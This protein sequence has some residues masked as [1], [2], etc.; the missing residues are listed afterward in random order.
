MMGRREYFN[1]HQRILRTKSCSERCSSLLFLFPW[2]LEQR[3][4]L[5][6]FITSRIFKGREP[7]VSLAFSFQGSH[8]GMS[9]TCLS[10][11][12][13]R[14]CTEKGGICQELSIMQKKILLVLKSDVS[15]FIPQM[16]LRILGWA[17]ARLGGRL[18]VSVVHRCSGS[19]A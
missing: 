5:G 9:R 17:S 16:E 8:L 19:P 14:L 15:A 6:E 1:T 11:M 10:D 4:L 13:G 2:C 7:E 12:K 18:V 3:S